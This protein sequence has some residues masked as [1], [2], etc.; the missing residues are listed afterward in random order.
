MAK[1]CT[2]CGKKLEEGKTCD[3][4]KSVVNNVDVQ[5]FL[6]LFK[7]MIYAP[8]D[9]MR[10]FTKK[11]NFNTAMILVGI[12]SLI[13][14]L[15]VMAVIKNCY[16][17]LMGNMIG[18]AY[19]YGK[20]SLNIP[21]A[22]TFFTALVLVFGLSFVYT[23][24]L[25]LVNKMIFKRECDF[26]AVYSLYGIV[27]TVFSMVILASTILMFVNVYLAVCLFVFGSILVTVYNYHGL[28]FIGTNDENKYG[29]IYLVTNV[30]FYIAIYI[31]SKIFS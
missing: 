5:K 16:S 3:C 7:G 26:K 18:G 23:S 19:S 24:I 4:Q 9:T 10:N 13:S 21:Y 31:I 8:I 17:L 22:K 6:D 25:Y 20:Y 30:L 14:G 1:F 12:L 28:K 15:F 29:Y 11:N 27:S 2:N